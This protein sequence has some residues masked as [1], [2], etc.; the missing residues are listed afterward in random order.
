MFK[1]N[2]KIQITTHTVNKQK[3]K[4]SERKGNERIKKINKIKIKASV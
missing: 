3:K 2:K 4:E 1:K